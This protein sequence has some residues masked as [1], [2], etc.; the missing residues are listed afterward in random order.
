[1]IQRNNNSITDNKTL[2]LSLQML[3]VI[4]YC[5]NSY[6]QSL[7]LE[8]YYNLSNFQRSQYQQVHNWVQLHL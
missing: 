7:S 4:R 2:R 6:L 8:Q 5:K 3:L 1:M